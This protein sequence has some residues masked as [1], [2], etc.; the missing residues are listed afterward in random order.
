ML[1]CALLWRPLGREMSWE[2]FDGAGKALGIFFLR[3]DD[4]A[5]MEGMLDGITRRIRAVVS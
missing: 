5:H 4:V 2:R 3:F 1:V